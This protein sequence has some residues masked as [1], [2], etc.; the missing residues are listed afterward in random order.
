MVLNFFFALARNNC[1]QDS[2]V[3]LGS[4]Y[5]NHLTVSKIDVSV[6]DPRVT[7]WLQS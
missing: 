1:L 2:G 3:G 7:K 4:Q 5:V 6:A